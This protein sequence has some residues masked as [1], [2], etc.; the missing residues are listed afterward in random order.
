MSA[1]PVVVETPGGTRVNVEQSDEMSEASRLPNA[2]PTT[3][4]TLAPYHVMMQA[5]FDRINKAGKMEVAVAIINS[6]GASM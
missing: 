3:A 2:A 1:A 5:A 6:L 4:A